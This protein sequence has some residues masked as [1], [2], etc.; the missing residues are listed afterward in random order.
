MSIREAEMTTTRAH[1]GIRSTRQRAAVSSAMAK[2]G[3]FR[4]AQDVYDDLKRQGENV[5]LATV[6]RT[7]QALA[8]SHELDQIRTVDGQ[9]AYRRCGTGHHHHLICRICGR[10]VEIELPGVESQIAKAGESHSFTDVDHEIELHG[11]C[12]DCSA[13]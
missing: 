6:Y 4:T 12:R 3:E 11:L 9:T 13:S 1:E 8:E 5:G 2:A 7:L 10:T